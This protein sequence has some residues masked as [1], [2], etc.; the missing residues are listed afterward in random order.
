MTQYI[1]EEEE[2]E[3]RED[4]LKYLYD[5]ME[6]GYNIIKNDRWPE[7]FDKK[8]KLN[9]LDVMHEY[10]KTRE[11]YEKCDRLLKL[12]NKIKKEEENNG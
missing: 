7:N 8:M 5:I 10:F 11:H 1:H 2:G 4:H 12:K 9:F 3:N 6:D